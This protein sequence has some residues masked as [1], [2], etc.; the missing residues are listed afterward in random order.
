MISIRIIP[1]ELSE[2]DIKYYKDKS[3]ELI[4]KN[5]SDS[6]INLFIIE[7]ITNYLF[8]RAEKD[9]SIENTNN[10]PIENKKLN[11]YNPIY[12][13]IV[14]L[15]N[16]VLKSHTIE[17]LDILYCFI[18]DFITTYKDEY[19]ALHVSGL[20]GSPV[21]G[22]IIT[23]IIYKYDIKLIHIKLARNLNECFN[24]IVSKYF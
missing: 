4:H 6:L 17:D 24:Y 15:I 20:V 10:I 18:N 7:Y 3:E 19:T 8:I 9:Y 14:K 23:P 11:N 16:N 21:G 1:G 12:D 22:P 2:E 5:P 13:T